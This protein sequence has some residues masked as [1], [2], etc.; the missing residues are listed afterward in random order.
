M[1]ESFSEMPIARYI[2]ACR[3]SIGTAST[4]TLHGRSPAREQ[5]AEP[6]APDGR[7]LVIAVAI[8]LRGV[9]LRRVEARRHIFREAL[10]RLER[11]VERLRRGRAEQAVRVVHRTQKR[12]A[13]I[14]AA[15]L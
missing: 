10:A 14:R 8:L 3:S 9:G 2:L 15:V 4:T 5:A 12:I 7:R 1:Y 6:E 13:L 11:K